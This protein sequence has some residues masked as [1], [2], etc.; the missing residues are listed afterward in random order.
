[1][2]QGFDE[3]DFKIIYDVDFDKK[4]DE[5]IIINFG[6]ITIQG[7][8]YPSTINIGRTYLIYETSL[9]APNKIHFTLKS[10]METFYEKYFTEFPHLE[11][12]KP[13]IRTIT[14][15]SKD[16]I[17]GV[18]LFFPREKIHRELIYKF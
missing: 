16:N 10:F 14:Y 15:N 8:Y 9:L 6:E 18:I 2:A 5:D 13:T 3:K 1:M 7:K 4:N 11:L 12:Q 17:Y